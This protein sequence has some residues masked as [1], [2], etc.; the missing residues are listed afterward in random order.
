MSIGILIVVVVATGFLLTSW[1]HKPF[2][3][4]F[5]QRLV[6]KIQSKTFYG[7][8]ILFC[9]VVLFGSAYLITLTPEIIEPFT[10]AY[11]EPPAAFHRLG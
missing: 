6:N 2:F 11:F 1:I 7:W 3:I 10:Q 4:R 8:S 9:S 5:E